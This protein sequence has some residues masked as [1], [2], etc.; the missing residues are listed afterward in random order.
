MPE[1]MPPKYD[2]HCQQCDDLVDADV[3][4]GRRICPDCGADLGRER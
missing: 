3:E 2:S 4:D 1:T